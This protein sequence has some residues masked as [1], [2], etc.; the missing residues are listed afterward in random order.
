VHVTAEAQRHAGHADI[1]REL[2][3]GSAGL[4]KGHDNLAPVTP[5]GG[6]TT[7]TESRPQPGLPAVADSLRC[8]QQRTEYNAATRRSS[9]P[10]GTQRRRDRD[11]LL[12]ACCRL[13][14]RPDRPPEQWVSPRPGRT[15]S[16]SE[17]FL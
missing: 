1:I 6:A 12:C 17:T 16:R 2:I 10:P 13:R 4:L 9:R 5:H 14:W 3:D 8:R 11:R 15:G 7:T